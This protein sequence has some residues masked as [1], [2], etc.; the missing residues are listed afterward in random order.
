MHCNVP[1]TFLGNWVKG[2]VM[3]VVNV[4]PLPGTG[5]VLLAAERNSDRPETGHSADR[6]NCS[7]QTGSV[8]GKKGHRIRRVAFCQQPCVI[9]IL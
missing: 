9:S 2:L 7:S 4:V 3:R 5:L 6:Q 8:T 1:S